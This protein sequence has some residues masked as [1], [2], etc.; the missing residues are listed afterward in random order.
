M[1]I[2]FLS[3]YSGH[4][5]RGSETYV[6]ELATRLGKTNEVTV[7]Q[8][9]PK[10]GH[11]N[12]ELIRI[13]TRIDWKEKDM[14]GT[15]YR[16][17]F[18]DYWSRLIARFT[19]KSLLPIWRG[20]FDVVIPI[21][22]GW[23]PAFVRLITWL[24]GSKM[25]V[26]GQSGM[27]W[28][29]RNNL[30]SFPNSFVALSR[31]SEL[32]AKEANPLAKN[33]C[34]IPN[35]VDLAKF[36]PGG[37]KYGV[38]LKKPIILCVGAL[39]RQKR[40]DLVIK[41]VAK[42]NNVSLLVAGDGSNKK[43]LMKVGSELL[44]SKFKLI[45][46]FYD[47]MPKVYRVADIFT[48]VPESSEAFGNVYVEAMATNLPVV[49]VDDEQRR[50]IVGDAGILVAP[51]DTE[52]YAKALTETL[53]KNWGDKPRKQAEKFDWDKIAQDYERLF[54]SLFASKQGIL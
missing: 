4:I 26:S 7:F 31:K 52:A 1:K 24:Q 22:G 20:K 9:G 5:S 41:A 14:T 29:D 40:I 27:G 21:N 44:G 36:K 43:A 54:K 2:A 13:D 11:G 47:E 12:Y 8:S 16:R 28:D 49:A 30:W 17:F 39:T 46:V 10:F 32:W 25:V 51:T 45:S 37:E 18:I 38:K 34:Y 6:Y 50:E 23:Q 3:F 48:L 33:I 53:N 35:G 15:V 42:L 19:I